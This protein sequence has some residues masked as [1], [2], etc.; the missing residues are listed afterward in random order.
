V[1]RHIGKTKGIRKNRK[2]K[3]KEK[4]KKALF[5]WLSVKSQNGLKR[6]GKNQGQAAEVDMTTALSRPR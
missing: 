2:E 4:K 6:E 3:E 1:T 5:D